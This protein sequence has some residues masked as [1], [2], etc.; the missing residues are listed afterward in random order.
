MIAMLLHTQPWR[1][2][3]SLPQHLLP[4]LHYSLDVIFLSLAVVLAN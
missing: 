1:L 2:A 3:T 4:G